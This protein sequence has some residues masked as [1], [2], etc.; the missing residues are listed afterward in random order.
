MVDLLH[1]RK[2][3][4]FHAKN[5]VLSAPF[6]M[7]PVPMKDWSFYDEDPFGDDHD[8]PHSRDHSDSDFEDEDFGSKKKKGK[9][10]GGKA[11]GVR[12]GK[13][14]NLV[15]LIH[16]RCHLKNVSSRSEWVGNPN[17]FFRGSLLM[18]NSSPRET[19]LSILMP[20]C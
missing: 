18:N 1:I 4:S 3:H 2:Q 12:T 14:L 10:K 11:K 13:L 19:F 6:Q 9:A 8:G 20:I 15:G 17:F 5:H 7:N 16:Q